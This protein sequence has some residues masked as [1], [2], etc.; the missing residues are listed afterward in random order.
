MKP[1]DVLIAY[2]TAMHSWEVECT[3]LDGELSQ[4]RMAFADAMRR[5][6]E[7]H[8]EIFAKYCSRLSCNVGGIAVV[9]CASGIRSAC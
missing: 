4:G 5:G 2:L 6:R 7:A 9:L 8:R 1:K 3:R